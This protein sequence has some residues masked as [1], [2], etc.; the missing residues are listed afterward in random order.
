MHFKRTIHV[1]GEDE[2]VGVALIHELTPIGRIG[3]D[4]SHSP[5]ISGIISTSN[6]AERAL[7]RTSF[8]VF[9]Q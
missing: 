7:S 3:K 5:V 9:D 4:L 1:R 2:R 8:V 6:V